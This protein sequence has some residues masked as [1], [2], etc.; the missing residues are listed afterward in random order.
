MLSKTKKQT[1]KQKNKK[2]SKNNKIDIYRL[3]NYNFVF[4]KT[5]KQKNKKRLTSKIVKS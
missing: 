2:S 4:Q 5:K 3:Y 1:K